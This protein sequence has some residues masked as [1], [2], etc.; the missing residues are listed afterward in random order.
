MFEVARFRSWPS[1]SGGFPSRFSKVAFRWPFCAAWLSAAVADAPSHM[2][3]RCVCC[4]SKCLFWMPVDRAPVLKHTLR[5]CAE[6]HTAVHVACCLQGCA[7]THT[8]VA[9]VARLSI[10]SWAG[11]SDFWAFLLLP[12][13]AQVGCGCIPLLLRCA[14]MPHRGSTTCV[15]DQACGCLWPPLRV[16]KR[17]P[18]RRCFAGPLHHPTKRPVL[19]C[20]LAWL[21]VHRRGVCRE[22]RSCCILRGAF[23]ELCQFVA[24]RLG[25][26]APLV[27]HISL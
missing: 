5:L 9:L 22:L 1:I 13:P 27:C 24:W 8:G 26:G 12:Q 16:C 11:M 3:A 6:V 20:C 21:T 10:F 17:T 18:A 15:S 23:Q 14:R 25:V 4:V 2:P 7:D 19:S